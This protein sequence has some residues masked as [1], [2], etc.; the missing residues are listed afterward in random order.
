MDRALRA[1]GALRV[2]QSAYGAQQTE[3]LSMLNALLDRWSA[4]GLA[5]P[6]IAQ[7]SKTLTPGTVVYS[8]GAGQAIDIVRPMDLEDTA[9]VRLNSTDYPVRKIERQEYNAISDK[10]SQGLPEVM[11]Y[12]DRFP[13]AYLYL[14]PVPDQ[15]YELRIDHLSAVSAFATAA[16]DQSIPP[17]YESAIWTSLARDLWPLYP[18][19]GVQQAIYLD[20]NRNKQTIERM[21]VRVP[22][23]RHTLVGGDYDGYS[24]T[25]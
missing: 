9:F 13:V 20:A 7:T 3:C 17:A 18:N 23:L 21:N 22:I 2:G 16:T 1:L 25:I 14:Y 10:T 5:I 4:D 15:A 24:D 19:P 11:F 8:V 6:Q 12:D